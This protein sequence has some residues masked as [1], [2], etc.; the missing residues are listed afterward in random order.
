MRRR[1]GRKGAG[2]YVVGTRGL[3]PSAMAVQMGVCTDRTDDHVE[4]FERAVVG[5]F[6]LFFEDAGKFDL[7]SLIEAAGV[8]MSV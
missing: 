1:F 7:A 3:E 2:E 5:I 4:L 8:S 6:E